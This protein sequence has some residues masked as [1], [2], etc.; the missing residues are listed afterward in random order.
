[1]GKVQRDLQ[2][3]CV[4]VSVPIRHIRQRLRHNTVQLYSNSCSRLQSRLQYLASMASTSLPADAHMMQD[5]RQ[6]SRA[7]NGNPKSDSQAS[8]ATPTKAEKKNGLG[9]TDILRILGGLLL[10]NCALSYFVTNDSV[11]WGWRP[12]FSKPSQ[13][14][15]WLVRIPP[16]P[17]PRLSPFL[18]KNNSLICHKTPPNTPYT[19]TKKSP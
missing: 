3:R 6:R 17:L 5:L 16:P 15:S 8:P 12:W 18:P 19:D 10:L 2:V 7:N 14:Q 9:V 4:P 13:L 1:M 11:A